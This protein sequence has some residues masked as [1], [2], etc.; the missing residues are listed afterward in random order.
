MADQRLARDGDAS[1][2]RLLPTATA[3][4]SVLWVFPSKPTPQ[5]VPALSPPAENRR[6]QNDS[7]ERSHQRSSSDLWQIAALNHLAIRASIG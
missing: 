4:P 1:A 7:P 2:P 3:E 6:L 5:G